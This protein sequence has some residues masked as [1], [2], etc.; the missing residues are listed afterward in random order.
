MADNSLQNRIAALLKERD[1]MKTRNRE[2]A[3]ELNTLRV[4]LSRQ[5]ATGE[6]TPQGN[7]IEQSLADAID[8]FFD[9]N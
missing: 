1:V 5:P 6:I 7:I 2:I 8:A 4:K 9:D 3:R